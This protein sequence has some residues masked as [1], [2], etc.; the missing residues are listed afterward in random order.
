[1]RSFDIQDENTIA[2]KFN[3]FRGATVAFQRRKLLTVS[4][5]GSNATRGATPKD[6]I[7]QFVSTESLFLEKVDTLLPLFSRKTKSSF[8]IKMPSLLFKFN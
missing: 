3:S 1:M 6:S 2:R 8:N 4:L 5:P 7:A